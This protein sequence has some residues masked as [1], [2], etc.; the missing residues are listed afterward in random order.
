[1]LNDAHD[2]YLASRVLSAS[3]LELVRLLYHGAI[4]AVQDAR[5]RLAEG[6]ILERSRSISKAVSI[7]GEL[8]TALDFER[9]SEIASRLAGLYDYMQKRLLEA[10]FKQIDAPLG[11]VLSLLT[12]L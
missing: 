8:T 12:T 7:L 3:P 5:H 9:S 4:G 11:E 1:M 2:S 6:K 10:N